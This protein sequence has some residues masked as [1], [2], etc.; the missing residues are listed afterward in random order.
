MIEKS[1]AKQRV[2]TSP[3]LI[4]SR[5]KSLKIRKIGL[6]VPREHM[7]HYTLIVAPHT[8]PF[9]IVSHTASD[10]HTDVHC[11]VYNIYVSVVH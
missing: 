7:N 8:A 1:Q 5:Y 11:T 6:L 10:S 3:N 2:L 9:Y 4:L